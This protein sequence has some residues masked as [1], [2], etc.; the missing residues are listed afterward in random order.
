MISKTAEVIAL[1]RALET[2]APAPVIRDPFAHR[3]LS[4]GYALAVQ[5]SRIARR[6]LLAYADRRA[7]GARTSAIAR[8]AFL[9]AAV[10]D[11]QPPQLVILGA[12]FDCR[13]HRMPELARTR[14]FEVD[15][16]AIQAFKRARVDAR[17][18]VTYVSVDFLRDDVA[19]A[20]AAAGWDGAQRTF[21]LWEGVTNYLDEPAVSRVLAWVGT[22]AP[23][24]AIA[25][26]YVHRGVIDGSTPFV[27]GARMVRDVAALGEPWTFGLLPED[28]GTFVAR[29]GLAIREDIGADDYRMRYLGVTDPGYA[30]YR[31]AVA[32]VTGAAGAGAPGSMP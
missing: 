22:L 21:V 9:D 29:A 5:L 3:F 18:N 19:A 8:T 27:G 6:P 1:Y 14:V 26:T 32:T 17:P 10:R 23:G 24:S 13:A 15:R 20:L 11:A 25:F 2:V 31:I 7:P 4:R 16:H 12:G 30:F 28:V